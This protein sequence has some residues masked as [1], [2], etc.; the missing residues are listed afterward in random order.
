MLGVFVFLV[1]TQG[2]KC[3]DTENADNPTK[4]VR[5]LKVNVDEFVSP[6]LNVFD[7]FPD[8]RNLELGRQWNRTVETVCL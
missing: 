8:V 3:L 1:G 6:A 5:L 7:G 2:V 4:Y